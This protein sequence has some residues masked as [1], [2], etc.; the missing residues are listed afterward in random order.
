MFADAHRNHDKH[1]A[2]VVRP[3]NPDVTGYL[4]LQV[5]DH[6]AGRIAAGDLAANAPLPAELRLAREYGVSLGTTRRATGILRERGL[7]ITLRCK[8]TFVTARP[9]ADGNVDSS[10]NAATDVR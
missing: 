10:S 5:A 7:V 8:G 4:Y 3:F 2:H 6:L 9:K 1:S